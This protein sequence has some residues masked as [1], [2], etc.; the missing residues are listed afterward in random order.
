MRNSS[1]TMPISALKPAA[2]KASLAR[3]AIPRDRRH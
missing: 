2:A 3:R 1:V